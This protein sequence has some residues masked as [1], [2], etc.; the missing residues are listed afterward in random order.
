MMFRRNNRRVDSDKLEAVQPSNNSR[1]P[2]SLKRRTRVG[3]QMVFVVLV[4]ASLGISVLLPGSTAASIKPNSIN[5]VNTVDGGSTVVKGSSSIASAPVSPNPRVTYN[6][7]DETVSAKV[8]VLYVLPSD[9]VD[10]AYDTNGNIDRSVST[11]QAW[12]KQATGGTQ[13]LRMDESNGSL[14]ITFFRL[15]RTDAQIKAS[16]SYVSQEV[17]KDLKAAGLIQS[18][19]IYAVYYDGGSTYSCGGAAW[20]PIV[21]GQTAVMY[22]QGTPPN[23]PTCG[24][25]T[26]G[27]GYM[28]YWEFA[29][30]HDLVHA[31][32]FVATCAPHHIAAGHVPE[33]QDLMYSGSAPWDPR[34]L[35]IGHDD[36]YDHSNPACPDLADS[37]YLKS[38]G[39]VLPPTSPTNLTGT[40]LKPGN[41]QLPAYIP[42]LTWQPST[43]NVGVTSYQIYKDNV[44]YA[45]IPASSSVW[46]DYGSNVVVPGRSYQYEVRALDDAGNASPFSNIVTLT[47][48]PPVSTD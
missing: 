11:F 37:P 16:G 46:T 24:S 48:P 18:G 8:Q 26:L 41:P 36:Y 43:D 33:P 25:N 34:Y 3:V 7:P 13:Q 14:D 30:L 32:G 17:E 22:L 4:V 2:L 1:Y 39:D 40:V 12:F 6:R 19:K 15:S 44:L 9:G 10:H 47:I 29:M 28:G 42:R 31:F 23:S 20:P 45:T 27:T 5:S 21:P 38:F 35:D